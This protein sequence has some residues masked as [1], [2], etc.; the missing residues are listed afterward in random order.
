VKKKIKIKLTIK[1]SR[2]LLRGGM[3]LFCLNILG[4][5]VNR[6]DVMILGSTLTEEKVGY[7][8][9]AISVLCLPQQILDQAVHRVV[10]PLFS[11]FKRD[12]EN[13]RK[14]YRAA[15]LIMA[16][17]KV[18]LY[19]FIFVNIDYLVFTLLGK[20]EGKWLPVIPV[21]RLLWF[22]PISN[23]FTVFGNHILLSQHK[24]RI[25]LLTDFLTI[26]Y[27]LTA[28]VYLVERFDL[29]GMIFT[30]YSVGILAVISILALKNILGNKYV[31][32]KEYLLLYLSLVGYLG[33]Y[34]LFSGFWKFVFSSLLSIGYYF[35]FFKLFLGEIFSFIFERLGGGF[36]NLVFWKRKGS[37]NSPDGFDF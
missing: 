6:V 35:I 29:S 2:L 30:R 21:I 13:L 33:I 11:K 10:Y 9:L 31:F 27:L 26:G 18:P 25:M 12:R 36:K 28:G 32:F 19:G 8:F 20:A 34:F 37:K 15:S 3:Y 22:W 23:P 24:D 4:I 14:I 17:L 5:V 7:Y 16:S 1:N